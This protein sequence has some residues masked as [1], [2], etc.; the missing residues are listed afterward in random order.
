MSAWA[1]RS[2]WGLRLGMGMGAGDWKVEGLNVYENTITYQG[3][4]LQIFQIIKNFFFE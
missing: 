1:G 3:Y 2:G 4:Y